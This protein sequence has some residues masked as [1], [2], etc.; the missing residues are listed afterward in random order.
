MQGGSGSN[1]TDAQWLHGSAVEA[2]AATIKNGAA[3][4]GMP[5]FAKTFSDQQLYALATL[6]REQAAAQSPPPPVANA[7]GIFNAAGHAFKLEKVAELPGTM[8]SMA[9]LPD[10]K[11]LATQ[12]EGNLWLVDQGRVEGPI[13][14]TPAVWFNVQGGLLEVALHP[15]YAQN[16]WVYLTFSDPVGDVSMT[17]VVRGRIREGKWVDQQD[18]FVADRAFYTDKPW[19]FGSRLAF[20]GD[21][22]YF[23]VGER[24]E[25]KLAQDVT[26]PKGKVFRVRDDGTIPSDNP[27]VNQP[28][29]VPSIWSYGH[30]NP[31]GLAV[32]PSNGD[33]WESE[34]GPRGGDEINLIVKGQNYGWPV[35]TYGMNYDG[36]PWSSTV[37]T[38][39][40][41]MAQPQ[42]Y[43]VPS[44]AVADID[45][46]TGKAFPKWH[47]QLLVGSLA[48]QELHL[49]KIDNR[50][51]TSD[52][53]LFKNLG[54]IRDVA[55]GPDGYPYVVFNNESSQIYRLVPADKGQPTHAKD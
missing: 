30:R 27:F 12:Q 15:R 44:I 3:G 19:H 23:S 52:Q 29:A 40:Q 10:G 9:F 18:I 1:L 4:G 22:L 13:K 14:D 37:K 36:T 53:L 35:I 34:H 21:D 20:V 48:K 25:S 2:I 42:H 33:L 47:N 16:G 41:G 50:A 6:I 49:L 43:W 11:I 54:R 17:R 31:Q 28:G 39:E 55:D 24:T 32:D 8:W 46:Y 45:F 7:D 51:V 38:H 5:A 26:A